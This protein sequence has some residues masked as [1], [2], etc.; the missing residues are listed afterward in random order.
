VSTDT[1]SVVTFDAE[2]AA[3]NADVN[4]Q[5]TASPLD[6][7]G[8]D[9]AGQATVTLDDLTTYSA[10]AQQDLS[11]SVSVDFDGTF[12]TATGEL[13]TD[14]VARTQDVSASEGILGDIVTP[15]LTGAA[16]LDGTLKRDLLGVITLDTGFAAPIGAAAID[17]TATPE[18]DGYALVGEATIALND[19]APYSAAAG[20]NLGGKFSINLDGSYTTTTGAGSANLVALTENISAG[21]GT[22]GDI[23]RPTFAGAAILQGSVSRDGLGVVTLDTD[24]TAPTANLAA[25]GTATPLDDGYVLHG[26]GDVAVDDISPYSGLAG[27]L[28]GGGVSVNL[29]GTYTTTTGELDAD[30]VTQTRDVRAGIDALDRIIAGLGRISANVGL[31]EVGRLRLDAIDVAFPNLTA[32]GTVAS[33]G[34]DTTANLTA[35]LRDVGIL[36]SD[37]S[38]PLVADISARQDANGWQVTGDATGPAQTNARATGRVENSGNLDLRV[39]GSAPLSLANLYIAPRRVSGQANFDL[40]VQGPPALSSVRGPI[41]LSDGRLSAPTLQL[42]LQEIGGT[43][44]LAGERVQLDVSGSSTDGGELNIS[45]PVDLSPHCIEQQRMGG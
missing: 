44:T 45:G 34:A 42:A 29:D 2:L 43:I 40:A 39:T 17:G 8:Y 14:L 19:L 32:S 12:N 20:E 30:V 4:A 21:T 10:L 11:G 5:G 37:F 9:L 31:S 18:G 24:F 6:E 1:Q 25:Q 23:I 26:Q 28:I 3:P 15:T 16:T 41:T 22:L 7:E 33:S 35:R 13:D 38:G 36:T 27:R